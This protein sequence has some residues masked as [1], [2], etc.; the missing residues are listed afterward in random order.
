[1]IF[2]LLFAMVTAVRSTGADAALQLCKPALAIKAN[3]EIATIDIDSY[4][5]SG[6]TRTL[7]GELTAFLR[8]APA[9]P[10]HARPNH[11]IRAVYLYSC[12]IAHGRVRS[13][14][15]QSLQ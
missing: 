15:I 7:S 11:V 8:A 13:A 1:M 3:G 9:P 10:G 14:S 6:A 4:R 12:Q 2:A 5:V